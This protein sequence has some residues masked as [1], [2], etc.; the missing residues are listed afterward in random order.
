MNVSLMDQAAINSIRFLSIDM[1]QKAQS[2]HPGLPLGAAPMA[3][4]LWKN[5]LKFNPQDPEWMNRDRFVLSAGHGSS[6]LYAMLHMM[7]FGVSINDLKSFRQLNSKTPGHP[8]WRETTGVDASTGPLGQGLG[9][10][11]G[12]AMAEKHLAKIYNRPGYKIFDHY[13]YALVGDGDLME[14]LSHEVLGIAGDKKLDKLVV[15]FDSNNVTLDGALNLSTN[16]SLRQRCHAD[17]WDYF[18]VKDG[19]DLS[20]LKQTI[21]AAK[22]TDHPAMIEVKTIIGYGSPQQGTNQVHGSALG[23]ENVNATRDFYQWNFKPFEIPDEIHSYFHEIVLNKSGYYD[24][25]QEKWKLYQSEYPNLYRQLKQS[26]LEIPASIELGSEN[27]ATRTTNHLIMQKISECNQNF[28]G[29]SANL[30]SSNK[31]KLEDSNAFT[32]LN[33]QGKNIYYG[34]REFGMA[35]VANGIALHGHTKTFVS[36]FFAFSDYMKPAIR[37]AAIQK[38]PVVYIFTHD[39]IAVGED[40]PT[41]EPIEQLAALRSI[42]NVTVYRPAD[43]KEVLASWRSIVDND[44]GPSVLVLTRQ[45]VPD[46]KDSK[47]ELVQKGAYTISRA[48]TIEPDGIIMATGSEVH[49]ALE[50]QNRLI[51]EG[52]DVSIVS[53]PSMELFDKQSTEYQESV[54][55]INI[56]TRLSVE[57]GTTFGWGK[58]TGLT[59]ANLGI[60][61]FGLSGKARQV[62]DHFNFT[63][64]NIVEQFISNFQKTHH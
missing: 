50:A 32:D 10:A 39:S 58:Y 3:Y 17:N 31:T 16:E 45:T 11:V 20:E 4:T 15:L 21:A 56:L 1:I 53:M 60:D 42:P 46:L 62:L 61:Q 6:M 29:G 33:P 38:L 13:T 8:E 54:L 22:K 63:T 40:G 37:L 27:M 43:A 51:T 18:L 25:W 23:D 2:G 34:V 19:N 5:E 41:H 14:G 28:W 44:Q 52:Y 24:Q 12:M 9:M 36:T 35:T 47:P 30:S 26:K 7:E 64:E 55:P 59:G 49:L 57:M 48:K